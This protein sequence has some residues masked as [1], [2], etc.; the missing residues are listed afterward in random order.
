MLSEAAAQ[1]PVPAGRRGVGR[2][3]QFE[4]TVER[5]RVIVAAYTALK[6]HG[7]DLTIA[8]ILS[9]AGVSTRS[10]YRHFPSK[11]ALLCAMYRRDGEYAAA[12]ITAR[13]SAIASPE[14]AVGAWVDEIFG[15]VSTG[16]RAER[17]SVLSSIPAS[18]AEGADE[19]ATYARELLVA[20][21]RTAIEAGIALGVFVPMDANLVSHLL[22]VAVLHGLGMTSSGIRPPAGQV[23]ITTFCL[24]A[25]G[26]TV[27]TV[28]R[29]DI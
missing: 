6:K 27:P 15:F 1:N 7:A 22:A 10:F 19:E 8:H 28:V 23:Q 4:D 24:R 9:A 11:D 16:R 17:V 12:R 25:L 2:P 3:R 14:L 21:L 13:L 5:E 26:A 20:P 29:N 18:R